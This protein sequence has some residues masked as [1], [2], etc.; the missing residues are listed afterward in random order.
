MATR[1]Y[2]P[3]AGVAPVSPPISAVDWNAHINVQ[4][5][6]LNGV[7]GNSAIGT[8]TYAPDAAD[9]LVAGRAHVA[10]FVSDLLPPQDIPA[11]Q[12]KIQARI[13]EAHANNNLFLVWKIYAVSEDG[14]T[15]LGTLLPIRVD[16]IEAGT[17]LTNRSDSATTTQ[18]TVTQNF[19]LVVELG[20]SGT[21]TATT[22]VQGHNG[23]FSFGENAATDLPEDDAATGAL[24][25]WVQFAR[26]FKTGVGGSFIGFAFDHVCDGGGHVELDISFNGSAPHSV[27]Y[28]VDEIREPLSSLTEEQR[29]QA[30]LLILKLRSA[31]KSRAQVQAELTAPGGIVVTV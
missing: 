18:V 30:A 4:R 21:P 6:P 31:G 2:F 8:L 29:E 23:S 20:L 7:Q 22:G 12:V 16:A 24:N 3:S 1:L 25:P 28:A 9:H 27:V 11:Q 15:V 19:R 10:Q 5:L 17:A 14:Q 13:A 26:N